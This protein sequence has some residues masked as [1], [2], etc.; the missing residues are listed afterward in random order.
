LAQRDHC[1]LRVP[2]RQDT[3]FHAEAGNCRATVLR[4]CGAGVASRGG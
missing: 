2:A 3:F 4:S 1:G